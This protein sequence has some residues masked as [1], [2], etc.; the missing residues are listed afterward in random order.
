MDNFERS[1]CVEDTEQH[2]PHPQLLLTCLQR[3]NINASEAIYIDDSLCDL[4]CAKQAGTKIT[5]GFEELAHV[6]QTPYGIFPVY[7]SFC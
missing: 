3:L 1:I 7:I 4:Q 6:F 5:T 2:K